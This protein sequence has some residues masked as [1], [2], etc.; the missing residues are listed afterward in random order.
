M[1]LLFKKGPLFYA[2][3]NIRLF[4]YL[5]F[6]KVNILVSNDL[7]TLPANYLVSI[8]RK[9]V[10]VYDA[11][12]Y[13]T[14]VP[15]LTYRHVTKKIWKKFE[16]LILPEIKYSYTVNHS[17]SDI[18]NQ[19]YNIQMKVVR[20][21]P[22]RLNYTDF[23]LPAYHLPA[24][25]IIYQG[26]V[27]LGRGLELLIDSFHFIHNLKC[28]I[29]GDGDI[30]QMIQKRVI[31]GN[32]DNKIFFIPSIPFEQLKVITQKAILGISIE[33]NRGLNYYYSLPNKLFDYIQAEIPVLVSDFPEMRRI[34]NEYGVGEV[35]KSRQPEDMALQIESMIQN[36]KCLLWKQNLAKAAEE[37]CWENEEKEL[38]KVYEKI[39]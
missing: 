27:N 15:E 31:T 34:I 7:D 17:I 5:L 13:F 30:L 39:L 19:M 38:L 32:L 28:V 29:V 11:H 20:N 23:S 33:E 18:Y 37:L 14:E 12:E 10:L 16:Q 6:S 35:L 3:Y 4:F 8:L 25:F 21:M 2:E 22:V 36:E 26:S 1:K 9:K 24:N